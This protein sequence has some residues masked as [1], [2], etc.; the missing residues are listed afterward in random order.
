MSEERE[1]CDG[2][3]MKTGFRDCWTVSCRK[4]HTWRFYEIH[5]QPERS[6]R[7][8]SQKCEMR[9]SELHGNMERD[10]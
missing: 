9:C 2:V 3:D 7:E 10:K 4:D 1:K 5:N 6:K 8:D